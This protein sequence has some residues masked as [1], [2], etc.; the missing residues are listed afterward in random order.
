MHLET[1]FTARLRRTYLHRVNG[2]RPTAAGETQVYTD[3]PC[4]LSRA[5]HVSAPQ[6]PVTG[7]ALPESAYRLSLF[8]EPEVRFQLGDRVEVRCHG[9]VWH[10]RTSDSFCYPSHTVTVVEVREVLPEDSQD[11]TGLM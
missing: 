2:F 1:A 8:T 9:Q 10:G 11:G 4:A 7:A 3:R 6:P 5:A